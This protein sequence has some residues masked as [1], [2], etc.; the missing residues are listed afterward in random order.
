MN[1]KEFVDPPK[2][3]RPSP[4]WSWNA[5]IEPAEVENRVR[6]M[7]QK[8]FGGFFMHPRSGLR[9]PYLEDDWMRA[10]RRAVEVAR[11][12]K[13]ESWLYDEDRWPSGACGGKTAEDK[14]DNLAMALTWTEDAA[15]LDEE[16][17]GTVIAYVA[18]GEDG[19]MTVLTENPDDLAGVGAFYERR[20]TRG[21]FWFNGENYADLLNPQTVSDFIDK[22]HERY[23]KL[24]R[25]DFGEYMPG[26][27]TDEPN[28]NRAIKWFDRDDQSP[29]SFPWTPGFAEFFEK[30]HDYSP[31]DQLHHLTSGTDEGF[32]F[33]HDFWRA[34][35]ERFIE[36]YTIPL[37]QWCREHELKL[38]G[39]YLYEDD[40]FPMVSSGGAVMPHYEY[41][42]VPGIDHL[43]R[44][45]DHPWTIKQVA[46]VAS[47]M[48]KKRVICEI[49]GC[50]GHSMSFK[51]MKWIADYNCALGVTFFCQHLV[52]YSL[53]GARKRDFPPTISY[54]Q[55]Y[56]DHY[57]VIND[58]LSRISWA[59]S[60]GRGTADILVMSPVNSAYGSYDAGSDSG[61]GQ[62][63]SI[64]DSFH[65]VIEE[66]SS[67]HCAYDIGDERIIAR[68]GSASGNTLTV[69]TAEYS[70]VVLPQ[71]FT[72]LA[73]TID[74]LESFDGTVIVMGDAPERVDGATDER[75]KAFLGRDTVTVIPDDSSQAVKA[76]IETTGRD[77][78]VE[79]ADGSQARKVLVNHR[80]DADAHIV[81]LANTD[82][83]NSAD[84]TVTVEALGGV[85]ELDPLTGR[86][87]RYASEITGGKTVIKTTL[88]AAGSRIFLIDTTQTSVA[89][90]VHDQQE[91]P[92]TIEGPYAFQRIHENVLTIDRCSL[93]ID[94]N[95][96]LTDEPVWKARKEIWRYTGIDEFEGYQP[97]VLEERNVRT[98]T[99]KTVLTFTFNVNDIPGRIDLA[100][101]SAD[102]FKV[103]INGTLVEP[104]AGSWHIDRKIPSLDLAG[105]VVEGANTITATTDFLWDT[106]IEDIYIVGDFAVGSEEDGFPIIK[107][108]ETLNTG[109]WVE[110]GYPFYSGSI[111]YKMEFDLEDIES[112]RYEVDLSGSKSSVC[113]VAVNDIE[114]GAVPFPPYRGDITGA[115]K[116]GAN[117]LEIEVFS[118]LRNTLGPLHHVEGDNLKWTGPEQFIDSGLTDEQARITG[119]TTTWTNKFQFAPYGFIEAPKLVKI[120]EEE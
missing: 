114:V 79:L 85:V 64:E 100:L 59:A 39:H 24:F 93:A 104:S 33:R 57:R 18:K 16:A 105:H 67:E 96:I 87:Y 111:I 23:S 119:T 77:V 52:Q 84:V 14:D 1:L 80:T 13:M 78:S 88:Y 53:T 108:P 28:V 94:G 66:L 95:K 103:E 81:F 46:S 27:F 86:A 97:W 6:D 38:T 83:E 68:H 62:L 63:K 113:Y 44:N 98:R 4:F 73:S 5:K 61:G 20:F 50:S 107:E 51:D 17:L 76:A 90:T 7:K 117:T 69:G 101:E 89:G 72:W 42:D 3:Y 29:F 35:N 25:Y 92:L 22:T 32:K 58:Y 91:E 19:A 41:L 31:L 48:G 8:G 70:C 118:T 60:Q 12:V 74:L 109:S 2:E 45:I 116:E 40:F 82:H 56:W 34:V 47:Q 102:R 71:A 99:N 106:E 55:P 43:G 115:L 75:M 110:Q 49:F 37:A 36:S 65:A 26:I 9:T 30:L 21:H 112:A 120:S 11:E 10:I 54:H 15:S